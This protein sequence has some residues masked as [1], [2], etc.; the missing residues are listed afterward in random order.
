MGAAIKETVDVVRDMKAAGF[1]DQQ[2]DAQ[3]KLLQVAIQSVMDNLNSRMENLENR[4]TATIVK[5][6]RTH[7]AII[8]GIVAVLLALFSWIR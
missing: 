4:I 5:E 8:V 3:V 2:V 1:T 7:T 6:Q